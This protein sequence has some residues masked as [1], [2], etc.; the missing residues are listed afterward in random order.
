MYRLA[1]AKVRK[2][3]EIANITLD[4]KHYKQ[5]LSCF[6]GEEASVSREN[7]WDAKGR[8]V[9]CEGVEKCFLRACV[10]KKYASYF[11]VL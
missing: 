7:F 6:E 2:L 3:F 4:N 8:K 1:T 11:V 5:L 9:G 10:L